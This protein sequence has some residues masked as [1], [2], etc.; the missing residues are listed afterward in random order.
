MPTPSPSDAPLG[1]G[2]RGVLSPARPGRTR[3]PRWEPSRTVYAA[4][5]IL[6]CSSDKNHSGSSSP[7]R[8][9]EAWAAADPGTPDEG[10]TVKQ[11]I[12]AI[13]EAMTRRDQEFL[14]HYGGFAEAGRR[15]VELQRLPE[16]KVT[17]GVSIDDYSTWRATRFADPEQTG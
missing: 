6:P 9:L 5:L 17:E 1:A 13:H 2:F 4:G 15:S 16:A 12:K 14:A 7:A 11:E 3:L 8:L 10:L